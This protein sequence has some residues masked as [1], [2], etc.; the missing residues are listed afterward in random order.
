MLENTYASLK[1]LKIYYLKLI[2]GKN[3]NCILWMCKNKSNFRS[4]KY[5]NPKL[6]LI[7][8]GSFTFRLL[9][10]TGITVCFG[11][12][13]NKFYIRG[14]KFYICTICKIHHGITF[15][16]VSKSTTSVGILIWYPIS[17]FVFEF[18]KFVKN[19]K[20]YFIYNAEQPVIPNWMTIFVFFWDNFGDSKYRSFFFYWR[21]FI[22]QS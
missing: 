8:P 11:T 9:K 20:L 6:Q 18:S 15:C 3:Q 16:F 19:M 12:N 21:I 22:S 7:R 1:F 13:K 4:F 17:V 14:S 10:T 2:F 5:T